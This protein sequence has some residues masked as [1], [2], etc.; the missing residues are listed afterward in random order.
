MLAIRFLV[1]EDLD[2]TTSKIVF[3]SQLRLPGEFFEQNQKQ[4]VP[5]SKF[6]QT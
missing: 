3:G 4:K 2:S 1:K 5:T 6:V